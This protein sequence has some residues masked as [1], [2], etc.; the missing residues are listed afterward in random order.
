MSNIREYFSR[1]WQGVKNH[2]LP[3][4]ANELQTISERHGHLIKV[5]DILRIE[6]HI[7]GK[8]YST[9]RPRADRAAIARSFIA[10]ALFNITTTEMLLDRL[11]SDVV[12]RRICGWEKRKDI[13]DS[14]T[15]SRAFKEFADANLASNVHIMVVKEFIGDALLGNI[16]RDSTEIEAREKATKKDK[17]M[18]ICEKGVQTSVRRR[19]RPKKGEERPKEP[20]KIERQLAMSYEEMAKQ[21]P[22]YCDVGSKLNSKGHIESWI[23]YKL[24]IDTADCGIPVTC[25]ISSAST[26]DSQVAIPLMTKTATNFNYLYDLMDSAYDAKSIRD[27]SKKLGHIPI[28]DRN[29][30]R[31]TEERDDNLQEARRQRFIRVFD[32]TTIRYK[33]RTVAERTN[34]RLKDEF[35]ARHIR[36]RGA[37]KV[38]SH[39]MFG[40]LALTAD[41]LIRLIS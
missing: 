11:R 35:G 15:M 18:A 2:L 26:H 41:Q 5:L 9:G 13:P 20:T 24:H 19:G 30:R 3:E 16:A 34:S 25:F 37:S 14:S 36:V 27:Y 6:D 23:G 32:S 39:L 7:K 4:L 12:F 29:Y 22:T 17:T 1:Y 40:V 8:L 21:I 31:L 38:F 10:K 28:I 33:A